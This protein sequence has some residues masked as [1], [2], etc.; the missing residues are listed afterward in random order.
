MARSRWK[1]SYFSRSIW[2]KIVSVKKNK[3]LRKRVIFD[4]SSSVPSCFYF[5]Y[6]R[7]HKG[8]RSRSLFI[9]NLIVGKKFGEFSFTRKPFYFPSKRTKKK[10][11]LVRR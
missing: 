2:R 9:N 4:R 6:F 11:L 7:V 8:R 3:K 10:N 5:K 1:L